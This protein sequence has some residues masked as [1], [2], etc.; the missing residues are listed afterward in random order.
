MFPKLKFTKLWTV[1]EDTP[2]FHTV[3]TDESQVRADMQYLF[4]EIM[5]YLNDTF[6][7][8]LKK[9]NAA[10][11]L[12]A[13][14]A[15]GVAA[16]VQ[17]LLD[18]LN[19]VKHSHE[20]KSLL[21]SYKQ[22][23]EDL[24]DA[25]DKK[26]NHENKDVLDHIRDVSS[27]LGNSVDVVPSEAAVNDA[28]TNISQGGVPVGS[29]GSDRLKTDT[30]GYS[31]DILTRDPDA[32]GGFT[33]RAAPDTGLVLRGGRLY[34]NDIDVTESVLTAVGAAPAY[35][36]SEQDIVPGETPLPN[37]TLYFVVDRGDS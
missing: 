29:I 2:Y 28:L 22:S 21:D 8:A 4:D 31:G 11:S 33:W 37:N 13:A 36:I 19:G 10:E 20:N 7:P 27:T 24:K 12:G 9:P 18:A 6:I 25:V 5:N 30:A 15:E 3:E 35:Q 17:A 14:D 32:A 34:Q 26:H 1:T 23:E 16:T